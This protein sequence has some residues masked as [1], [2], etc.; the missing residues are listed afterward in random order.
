[1]NQ[2]LYA[3]LISHYSTWRWCCLFSGVWALLGLV[4]TAF[5]YFPPER[6]NAIGRIKQQ[7]LAEID[8]VGAG[9]SI[10]GMIVFLGKSLFNRPRSS[11]NSF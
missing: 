9:L 3:Q 5:F 4:F 1:M 11:A 7:I 8:Y 2:A 6:P 10:V